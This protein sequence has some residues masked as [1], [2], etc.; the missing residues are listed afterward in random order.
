M[1]VSGEEEGRGNVG[2][3]AKSFDLEERLLNYSVE[4]I[5]L[6]EELPATRAG[7]HVAGQLLRSGTSPL[8]NHAE[9]QG[10]ESMNDFV[11]KL[12]ISLKELRET[13]RWLRLVKRVP[14]LQSTLKLDAV[15]RETDELVRIFVASLRTANQGRVPAKRPTRRSQAT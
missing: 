3:K 5:R 13:H 9:A 12:R 4:I 8:S 10:A 7:N 14:L 1:S 6:V 11:H 15:L 2:R